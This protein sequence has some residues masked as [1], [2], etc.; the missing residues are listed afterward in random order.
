VPG[1][2]GGRTVDNLKVPQGA[3]CT[4]NG[5]YVKGT[6][7]VERAPP[8]EPIAFASSATCRARARGTW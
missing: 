1:T 6:I 8:S 4:L 5:T 7:K 3:T 2:I